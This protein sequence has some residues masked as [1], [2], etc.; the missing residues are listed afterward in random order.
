LGGDGAADY[1]K[2]GVVSNTTANAATGSLLSATTSL[3]ATTAL[4]R[5]MAALQPKIAPHRAQ[6]FKSH[7]AW[8]VSCQHYGVLAIAELAKSLLAAA[9]VPPTPTTLAA[10][11]THV[12]ASVAA[13]NALFAAQRDA[14]GAGECMMARCGLCGSV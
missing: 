2:D 12:N 8:Q 14:E 5:D 4:L 10:A 11:I 9:I 1:T 7:A 13:I 6:F 3:P